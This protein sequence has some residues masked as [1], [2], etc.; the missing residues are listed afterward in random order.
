[1]NECIAVILLPSLLRSI[2]F[3]LHQYPPCYQ[4]NSLFRTTYTAYLIVTFLITLHSCN[5]VNVACG[6]RTM[7]V[8]SVLGV[9]S[10]LQ[11][12]PASNKYKTKDL[13]KGKAMAAKVLLSAVITNKVFRYFTS[14]SLKTL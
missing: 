14:T 4:P 5:I 13:T 12:P 2:S 10:V 3:T 8:D 1:M 11:H 6:G 7:G 9:Y